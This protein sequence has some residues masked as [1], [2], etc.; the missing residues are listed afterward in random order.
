MFLKVLDYA[1]ENIPREKITPILPFYGY[2]WKLTRRG[3]VGK[4]TISSTHKNVY[5]SKSILEDK[6][7]NGEHYIRT[8]NRI[9]YQQDSK[10]MNG[11]FKILDEKNIDNMGGW[12]S[13]HGS[14]M[15]YKTIDSWKDSTEQN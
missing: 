9:V 3:Y 6:Y 5:S 15:V 4:G 12:R 10:T 14:D 1:L 8:K 2:A 13:S 11:R 7:I